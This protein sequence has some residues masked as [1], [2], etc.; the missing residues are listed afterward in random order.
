MN[1]KAIDSDF[2]VEDS[3]GRIKINNAKLEVPNK[4]IITLE[5]PAKNNVRIHGLYG[6]NPTVNLHDFDPVRPIMSFYNFEVQ[7]S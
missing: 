7:S 2:V 5:N 6:T 1:D 4:V 3:T